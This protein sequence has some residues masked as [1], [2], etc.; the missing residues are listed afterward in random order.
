MRRENLELFS[1][2]DIW[3]ETETAH[4][5]IKYQEIYLPPISIGFWQE[6]KNFAF[7]HPDLLPLLCDVLEVIVDHDEDVPILVP[8]AHGGVSHRLFANQH[9]SW[10]RAREQPIIIHTISKIPEFQHFMILWYCNESESPE[11]IWA[12]HDQLFRII[13]SSEL[14]VACS[15]LLLYSAKKILLNYDTAY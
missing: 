1:L 7:F 13:N 4:S 3:R 2:L 8:D 9:H 14:S 5:M 12:W 15:Y 10:L 11:W 6:K